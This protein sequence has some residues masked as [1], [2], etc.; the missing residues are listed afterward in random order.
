MRLGPLALVVILAV[1]LVPSASAGRNL[2]VGVYGDSARFDRLTHQHSDSVLAYI[3]W[4]QGRTWGKP[5]SYFLTTLGDRPHIAL[6]VERR[7]GVITPQAIA[8]GRGDA[9]LL[10][11]AQ[12][13]TDSGKP[14]LLRPLGEMNNYKSPYCA[15]T[16]GGR[17]R[18]GATTTAWYR[19]AF[20]RID[21]V[22]HGGTAAD[23]SAKLRALGMPG[24]SS[25]VPVNPYPNLTIVWNPLAV[26][27]PPVRG[28]EY[29]SYFPG[30]S[31]V[32]AVG[33]DYYDFGS[34]SFVR[35][36]GLYKAF[37]SKPFMFPEWGLNRDDPGFIRAFAAFVRGHPRI[38]F[39]G[40]YNGRTGGPLDLGNEP[41]SLAA[42]RRYIVPLTR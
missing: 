30:L 28:N 14:V 1:C 6:Q 4:D 29:R 20:Q 25:D 19:K 24:V 31:Y 18:G 33:N 15:F 22:L 9:H 40:F 7:G 2:P 38:K 42:Y 8:L 35:T 10:G 23:L 11:L 3:G 36:T 32:D 16:S 34:Y 17:R 21:L 41:R 13:I 26:G 5:Y 37:P 39:I 27:E 12:A